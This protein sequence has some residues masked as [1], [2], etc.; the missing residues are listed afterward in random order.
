L[1]NM[2]QHEKTYDER[3]AITISGGEADYPGGRG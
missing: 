3:E 1:F 2:P